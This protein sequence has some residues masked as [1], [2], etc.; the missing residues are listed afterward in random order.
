MLLVKQ[1]FGNIDP[2]AW[3]VVGQ[4]RR[5][6]SPN[7]A[8]SYAYLLRHEDFNVTQNQVRAK[9]KDLRAHGFYS[10]PLMLFENFSANVDS[11]HNTMCYVR[12]CESF[13][14]LVLEIQGV[15]LAHRYA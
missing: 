8:H 10:D 2:V 11:V 15:E 12:V 9:G 14:A 13:A 4:F 7:E 3:K 5:E 1:R 6:L